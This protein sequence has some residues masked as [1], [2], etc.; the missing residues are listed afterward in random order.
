MINVYNIIT[1]NEF[2]KRVY[3]DN[4]ECLSISDY[5]EIQTYIESEYPDIY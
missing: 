4:L 1:D 5:I 2:C 3:K